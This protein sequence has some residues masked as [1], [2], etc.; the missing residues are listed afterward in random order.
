MN[1]D[2]IRKRQSALPVQAGR[3][4]VSVH[5]CAAIK[6]THGIIPIIVYQVPS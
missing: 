5:V 2:K 1:I 3:E 4:W 6:V